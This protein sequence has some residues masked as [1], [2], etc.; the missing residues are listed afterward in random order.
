MTPPGPLPSLSLTAWEDQVQGPAGA[1]P[2]GEALSALSSLCGLD[3]CF[4]ICV[5]GTRAS[6]RSRGCTRMGEH[7]AQC[8]AGSGC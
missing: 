5:T 7:W 2:S 1:S 6:T 4:L 3:F 8:L